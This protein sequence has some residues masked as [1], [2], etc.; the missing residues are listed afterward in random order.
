MKLSPVVSLG[1]L[2]GLSPGLS[3][4]ASGCSKSGGGD[5]CQR[6]IDKSWTV[7]LE[8]ARL[9]GRELDAAD[10]KTVVEQCRKAMKEGKRDPAMTCVL[11]AANEA[12][13][14][15]CYMKGFASYAAKSKAIEARVALN[16]IGRSAKDAFVEK[17]GFP[18]G[19]VGPSPA[20]PCCQQPGQTCAPNPADF[21]D[22][23]WQ[24]LYFELSSPARFQYRYESDGKTFTATAV[25][26]LAC[27]GTLTT[28]TVTGSVGAD[29]TP[30]VTGP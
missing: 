10:R 22:P 14:R 25:G 29:G 19:K 21:A 7:L 30:Q 12:A 16:G 24:A 13:V 15:D 27:D 9:R 8:M 23:V 20:T 28:E 3:L 2:L 1:V 6:A 4:V 5:E 11:A 18:V 26:D 17:G